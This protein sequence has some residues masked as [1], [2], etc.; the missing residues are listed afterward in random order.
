MTVCYFGAYDRCHGRNKVLINGLRTNGVDVVECHNEHPFKPLRIPL[1][2]ARFFL[3]ARQADIIVVGACGHAYVPLAKALG[4]M[5]GKPVVFDAFVS[6]YDTA[7]MDRKDTKA[8]S[9]RAR[10]L[11]A[12][13]KVSTSLADS[14]V[15]DTDEHVEYYCRAVGAPKSKLRRI[16]IGADTDLFYLRPQREKR[17]GFLVTF[18]GTFIPLQGVEYI[19][20]AAHSLARYENIR[21]ELIGSG[22]TYPQA[23]NLAHDLKVNNVTFVGP[24]PPEQVP[25]RLADADVCLGIFGDTDKAHRVIPNKVYEAM[26]MGKPVITGDTPA[27]RWLFTHRIHAFLV[28]VA[29][30]KA[31]ADAVVELMENRHLRERLSHN[32]RQIFLAVATPQ[33]L[34][35]ELASLCRE[36]MGHLDEDRTCTY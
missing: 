28:P 36:V 21:F 20:E 34:G 12:L 1:L 25:E 35:R 4:K 27:A 10:Y 2:A 15:M 30:A 22:Q 7:V 17:Q 18:V 24:V 31:I 32:G 33:I 19:I 9:W 14:V 5:T 26:A 3:S 23:R 11:Q 16:L 8:G 13:D 6:Q 29:D